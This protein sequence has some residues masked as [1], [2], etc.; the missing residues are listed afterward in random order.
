M[1]NWRSCVTS[2]V[3]QT[4]TIGGTPGSTLYTC[5]LAATVNGSA[6]GLTY[7]LL[8]KPSGMTIDSD[9][10]LISWTPGTEQHIAGE[11]VVVQVTDSDDHTTQITFTINTAPVLTSVNPFPTIGP[12]MG[13]TTKDEPITINISSFI[14]NG[15]GTTTI[16]DDDAENEVGGIAIT[17][18]TGLGTWEYS[19]DGT[20][21]LAM[22]SI[23]DASALLLP[24]DAQLRYTPDGENTDTADIIYRAWDRTSGT[25]GG[26]ADLSNSA[27]RGEATAFSTATDAATI[28]INDAPVLTPVGP[29]MGTTDKDTPLTINLTNTFINHGDGTT[30]ITDPDQ[31]ATLGGIAI[32]GFTGNG[33]WEYAA[34]IN[35]SFQPIGSASLSSALLLTKTSA[36]LRYTPDGEN[37]EIAAITYFA[38]DNTFSFNGQ[39][40]DLSQTSAHGGT[41]AF[42]TVSDTASLIV[43]PLRLY[44]DPTGVSGG[45]GI[46]DTD[47][48]DTY[49][50]LGSPTGALSAWVNGADVVFG[51]CGDTPGAI[52]IDDY[53]DPNGPIIV[54]SITFLTDGYSL[55]GQTADDTLSI[56]ADG[57]TIE[58]DDGAATIA[59]KL[60]DAALTGG[61]L[62]KTG[63]G[64]LILIGEEDY[65][66]RSTAVTFACA[67]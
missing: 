32:V 46:W 41:T 23:S 34:F 47:S 35:S 39:R 29:A 12:L 5:Q 60:V 44:W 49:W 56:A 6:E 64:T 10:G 43:Y 19:L 66:H 2:I 59:C 53:Q 9:T 51:A 62:T 50:H 65:A 52:Y 55:V 3:A 21:F 57:T 11:T 61:G 25:N 15:E 42:S 4:L 38:W 45:D 36:K 54:R 22:T 18:T 24:Q 17:Y 13:A 8:Q 63:D 1:P 28:R 40:A 30:I 16:T 26:R 58:V 67:A 33:T 14:N 7:Q 37:G 27:A 31:N 48:T 20:T